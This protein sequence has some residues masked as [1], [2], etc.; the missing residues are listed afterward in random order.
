VARDRR[1]SGGRVTP[2]RS[3]KPE[4]ST[5]RRRLAPRRIGPFERPDSSA[6][7]GQVG[8]RPSSPAKLALFALVYA[9]CGVVALIVLRG[10]LRVVLGIVFFGV[11]LLWLRGA[12]TAVLRQQQRR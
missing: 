6:P 9:A 12:A 11:A 2:R 5:P 1:K 7:L 8:R 10:T 3:A 4:A